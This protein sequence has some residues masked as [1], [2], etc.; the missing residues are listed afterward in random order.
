[1]PEFGRHG[2]SLT[3]HRSV[4]WY[5]LRTSAIIGTGPTAR[6]MQARNEPKHEA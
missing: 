6:Q 1:M 2:D 5:F 4:V 3:D